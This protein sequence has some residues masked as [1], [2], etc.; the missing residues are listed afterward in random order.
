MYL[1]VE[2]ATQAW[3]LLYEE[4]KLQKDKGFIQPSR[5]GNVVGEILN[6]HVVI[7]D[8]TRGIVQSKI[9][10]MPMRYAVGEL[11]WY[12]SKSNKLNDIVKY[13]EFWKNISDDGETLNSA[14]GYRIHEAFGFDQWEYVK[15]LLENDSYSRQAVVHIKEP[16]NQPT[17]DL[18]CTVALQFQIRDEKLYLTTYMRSNDIW[19]GFPYDVFAFTALQ[20]KMAFEL[21]VEIGEY[22]HIAGSL[23]LYESDV[24]V[25]GGG[26]TVGTIDASKI[27][28]TIANTSMGFLKGEL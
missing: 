6:A 10:K 5:A 26:I 13:S 3:D 4:L 9:R 1:Q 28:A 20:I 17:K 27:K 23:H 2:N 11:I 16:S 7:K 25:S 22:H 14:Y 18:P 15:E 8:P 19:K 24:P 12:L 21:G